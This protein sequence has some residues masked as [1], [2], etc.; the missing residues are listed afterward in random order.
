M[1]TDNKFISWL[2]ENEREVYDAVMCR[3]YGASWDNSQVDAYFS[4]KRRFEDE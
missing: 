1:K 3:A 2:K 4:A